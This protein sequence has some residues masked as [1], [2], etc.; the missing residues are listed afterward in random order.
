[1]NKEDII[2]LPK[3]DLHCHLDGSLSKTFLENALG[4]TFTMEELSVS[5]ECNSLVEYLEKFDIPLEA[6]NTIEN[7]KAATV[8]VMR[9]AS[10]EGVRYIEIRFAPLL[11]VLDSMKT[12]DV[13]EAVI[14]GINEGYKLFNIHGNAICCAMTHHDIEESKAMFKVAREYYGFGVAGLDLAGDEAN[15]PIG[16]FKDLF[17][18]ATDLG[19]NFTIHAGEAG[20]KS[21]IE[22]AIEYG[23][24]RIGHGIAMRNDE[25]LLEL[26]KDR[27]I[28]IEMCP[29]SNY[30]TK[31]V[32]KNETYPYADY[33]KR[34]ILATVNTDNRLVSN[35]S[36]TNEILFLQERNMIS[37]SDIIQG[38]RNA[39]EVSFASDNIKDMLLKELN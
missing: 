8:D 35:T 4:R 23:A 36:I 29:I 14:A 30:Q 5:M 13:I 9:S 21:N 32:G 27:H 25:R 10:A 24:K 3:L 22:G 15:H 16:E 37:D 20:P 31:A 34:G 6:M 7:I 17:K 26:A 2:K 39:I 28:G 11:S 38:I 33:I 19:M 18:Y 12:V 1:M